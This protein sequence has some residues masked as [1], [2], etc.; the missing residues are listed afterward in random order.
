LA[1]EDVVERRL[2]GVED[3]HVGVGQRIGVQQGGVLNEA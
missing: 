3:Q 2:A 1:G